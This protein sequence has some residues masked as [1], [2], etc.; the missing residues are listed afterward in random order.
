MKLGCLVLFALLM[1]GCQSAPPPV[2]AHPADPTAEPEYREDEAKLAAMNRDAA[3]ML[4]AGKGDAA[5]NL[6]VKGEEVAGRLLAVSHPTLAAMEAATDVDQLY[7][8][9]LLA[10]KRYGW[11]RMQYQ[12]NL[13]RWKHWVPQ[14]EASAKRVDEARKRIDECDKH[15]AQ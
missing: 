11:A 8:D 4:K 15:M 13:A 1:V 6:V 12:K 7:G 2:A 3:A 14:T 5:S 10:N 9:M